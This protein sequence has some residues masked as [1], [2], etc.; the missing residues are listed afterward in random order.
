MDD[1]REGIAEMDGDTG[2]DERGEKVKK[3]EGM[4]MENSENAA[5]HAD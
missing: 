4:R 5:N 2:A 3:L 1:E